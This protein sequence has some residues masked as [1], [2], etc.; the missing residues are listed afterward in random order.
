LGNHLNPSSSEFSIGSERFIEDAWINPFFQLQKPLGW[1]VVH[2]KRLSTNVLWLASSEN[3]SHALDCKTGSAVHICEQR[4]G[5][6]SSFVVC[7]AI[8]EIRPSQ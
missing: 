4:V 7:P 5:L 3:S 1:P 6:L 2:D 8:K